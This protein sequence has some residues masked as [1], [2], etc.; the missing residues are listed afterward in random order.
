[1]WISLYCR[2]SDIPVNVV[3]FQGC[4]YSA[5]EIFIIMDL[6]DQNMEQFMKS[7]AYDKVSLYSSKIYLFYWIFSVKSCLSSCRKIQ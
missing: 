6:A 5:N 2:K 1:M 7:E 4:F 3:Q